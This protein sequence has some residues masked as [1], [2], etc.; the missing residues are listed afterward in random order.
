[1]HVSTLRLYFLLEKMEKRGIIYMSSV[2]KM[3]I[4]ISLSSACTA[5]SLGE[6]ASASVPGAHRLSLPLPPT[7]PRWSMLPSQLLN[8]PPPP[9]KRGVALVVGGTE[10]PDFGYACS[11][12]WELGGMLNK[13]NF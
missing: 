3:T 8:L 2:P 1:M 6:Y 11:Q 12:G 4:G 7:F 9:K 10:V 5:V 13:R